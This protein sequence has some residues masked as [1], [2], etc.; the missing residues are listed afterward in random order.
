[1]LGPDAQDLT[2]PQAAEPALTLVFDRE[3]WSPALF[4]RLALH[5]VAVITWHRAFKGKAWPE[6]A[7]RSAP[8]LI[9]G[10]GGT[11]SAKVLLAEQRLQLNNGPE[12]RQVRRLLANGRQVPFI[13]TDFH[14]P[15]EQVAGALF[16]R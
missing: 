10:P 12:V 13:T 5:G 7:F 2:A 6:T 9:H 4:L 11:R 15:L 16:S 14:M 3:G 1:M 8:A